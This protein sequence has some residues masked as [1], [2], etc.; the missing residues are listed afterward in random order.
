[1]PERS[2]NNQRAYGVIV[3]GASAGG[4]EM[5]RRLVSGLPADLPA[6]LLV[7]QHLYREA[8]SVLPELLSRWGPL[9][10]VRPRDGQPV[11]PGSIYVAPPDY[12]MLVSPPGVIVLDHGPRENLHRPA[13]DPLFRSAARVYGPH[14]IGVILSGTRDDGVAG[15]LAVQ[16]RGG[17]TI[18]QDPADAP[19]PE[20]P[21][22]T[23][24]Q[25]PGIDQIV[26][27]EQMAG[28]LVKWVDE[29]RHMAQT[30]E[31]PAG[32][33]VTGSLG[34]RAEESAGNR[35]GRAQVAEG[36]DAN[37]NDPLAK[38]PEALICPECGGALSLEQ[39]GGWSQYRCHVGH[40]FGPTTLGSAYSEQ[41]EQALWA[42]MR[43]LK[44][45]ATLHERMAERVSLPALREE[46][47]QQA[48]SA[49][50]QAQQIQK[51]LADLARPLHTAHTG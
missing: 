25:V 46:Y 14:T 51:L 41:V 19:Y 38:E 24:E 2:A 30:V 40:T 16:L 15:I 35:A 37:V 21:R 9:P 23:V 13:I 5:L 48:V 27:I 3:I 1:M 49:R 31:M 45:S 34:S 10:A 42:A 8:E 26:P 4:L 18:V 29:I 20:M 22:N 12:H 50:D 7:V 32:E 6:A 44:E 36:E 47:R 33:A 39:Q 43:A 11:E 28:L 17:R